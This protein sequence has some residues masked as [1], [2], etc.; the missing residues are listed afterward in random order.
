VQSKAKT[1][2]EYLDELPDDRRQALTKLRS[3]IRKA[4]PKAVEGMGY[5]MITYTLGELL[6]ALGSQKG[7]MALYACSDAVD[8]HR[9][10]LGKLNCGKGCIRFKKLQDLP[11]DAVTDIL[12]DSVRRLQ[13]I[14]G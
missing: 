12:K 6:C 9:P 13:A 1:A 4:A 3:L 8:P 11:L 2:A 7:Y 5:G 10:R 14:T